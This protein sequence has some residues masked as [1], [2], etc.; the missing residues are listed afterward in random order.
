MTFNVRGV[1]AK[2]LT[3][4]LVAALLP[5]AIATTI[6]VHRTRGTVREQVGNAR[7]DMAAQVASGLD[8]VMLERSL[9]LRG[10]AT[11][12]EIAAAALGYGDSA[13]TKASLAALVTRSG[14]LRSARLYSARGA[15]VASS[16]G[17]PSDIEGAGKALFE[18]ALAA[19][20][21][22][23]VGSVEREAGGQTVVNIAQAV[24]TAAGAAGVLIVDV[25][26]EAL[27]VQSLG[28]IERSS[29]RGRA[30]TVR[31][32]LVNESG[33]VIGSTRREEMLQESVDA[34][35]LVTLLRT[36][37]AGTLVT[38]LFKGAA[39]LVGYAPLRLSGDRTGNRM[40]GD[41]RAGVIIAEET[42]FA[43]AQASVLQWL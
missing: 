9:E 11:S 26:W 30:A 1:R 41:A 15:L 42:Q 7:A 28:S 14:L 10:A 22:S 19:P 33:R 31:A 40:S 36:D 34:P 16:T 12:G 38:P 35:D 29:H 23:F 43:F 3:A 24:T 2:L 13:A 5:L 17:S 21:R 32:Y 4:V 39:S 18:R 25:D 8:R 27:M 6:A 20:Q 37:S